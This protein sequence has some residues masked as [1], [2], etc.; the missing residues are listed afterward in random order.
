MAAVFC[1]THGH[2]LPCVQPQVLP[3]LLCFWDRWPDHMFLSARH[4]PCPICRCVFTS[5]AL[6]FFLLAGGLTNSV[7]AYKVWLWPSC[8]MANVSQHIFPD[9]TSEADTGF[10]S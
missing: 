9:V 4:V 6:A 2:D 8:H 5:I 1:C 7:N 10:E 3:Q